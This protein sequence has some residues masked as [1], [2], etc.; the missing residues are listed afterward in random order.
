MYLRL[1]I[2]N[3]SSSLKDGEIYKELFRE[4]LNRQPFFQQVVNTMSEVSVGMVDDI[5]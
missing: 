2:V 1:V 5:I 3:A 4:S